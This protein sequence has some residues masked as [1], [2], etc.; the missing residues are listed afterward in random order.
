MA[1]RNIHK[2]RVV[3]QIRRP[4]REREFSDLW[5]EMGDSLDKMGEDVMMFI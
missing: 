4:R 3:K 1:K 2:R 5:D